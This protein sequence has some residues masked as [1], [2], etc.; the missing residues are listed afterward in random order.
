VILLIENKHKITD[1][2]KNKVTPL[3][4]VAWSNEMASVYVVVE[5]LCD[6][7]IRN[8]KGKNAAESAKKR[9]NG[10]RA[11]TIDITS[12]CSAY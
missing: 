6:L 3:I 8:K 4:Y 10:Q 9:G 2:D 11:D 7:K 12:S 1:T 5:A